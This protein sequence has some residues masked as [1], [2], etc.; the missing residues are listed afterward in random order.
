MP[1][2]VPGIQPPSSA[3]SAV[4][5]PKTRS[6]RS[7]LRIRHGETLVMGGLIDRSEEEVVSRVPILADIPILGRAFTHKDLDRSAT[8]LLVFI[9]PHIVQEPEGA[10]VASQV[11]MGLREQEPSGGR[12]DEIERQLNV[13]EHEQRL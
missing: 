13:L 2:L 11:P 5:D 6:A 7:L 12:Q 4:K 8:E 10:Q 9:T 3:G 1:G